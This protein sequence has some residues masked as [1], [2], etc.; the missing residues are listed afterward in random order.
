MAAMPCPQP[1]S[2]SLVESLH[3]THSLSLFLLIVFPFYFS[4]DYCLFQRTQPSRDVHIEGQLQFC[5]FCLQQ[6]SR[7]FCSRIHLLVFLVARAFPEQ[8]SHTVFQTNHFFFFIRLLRCPTLA[9]TRYK[10]QVSMYILKKKKTL[11]KQ[12]YHQKK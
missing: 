10:H 11:K 9:F 8:S 2:G 12:Y 7:H 1:C 4:Y 3:L 6:C 5:H